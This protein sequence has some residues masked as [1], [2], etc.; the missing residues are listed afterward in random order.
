MVL[1]SADCS[2]ITPRAARVLSSTVVP[3]LFVASVLP[4]YTVTL[5]VT[6]LTLTTRSHR[7]VVCMKNALPPTGLERRFVSIHYSSG[8]CAPWFEH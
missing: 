2:G 5:A 6:P 3:L 4:Q 8:C 7:R 1:T